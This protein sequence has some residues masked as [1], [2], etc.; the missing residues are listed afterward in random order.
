M[1]KTKI[2]FYEDENGEV[3]V[4]EWL[5]ALLKQNRKAYANCVT[6]IQQLADSGHELR[7]P[8]A[9]YLQDGIYELRAKHVNVQYR[10]LYFFQGQN[11]AILAQAIVK[12]QSA[13]PKV[14]I[15]RALRRKQ[16]FES[17]PDQH[18]YIT[19]IE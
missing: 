13:V 15:D 6:R 3:P 8:A 19:E 7:R 9:D 11:I 12:E 2:I 18:T 10:I 1:A 17:N 4:L 5:Q 16:R 14:E